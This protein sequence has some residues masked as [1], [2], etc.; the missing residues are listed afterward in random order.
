MRHLCTLCI[1][2]PHQH[3][4]H[5]LFP[6]WAKRWNPSHMGWGSGSLH[7]L[8]QI[9]G[10]ANKH[11]FYFKHQSP[12]I[13]EKG[14]GPPV[15]CAKNHSFIPFFLCYKY[16]CLHNGCVTWFSP[17]SWI[18]C[19]LSQKDTPSTDT[20][21]MGRLYSSYTLI[22]LCTVPCVYVTPLYVYGVWQPR[23]ILHRISTSL[24]W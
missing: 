14:S 12:K 5:N 22:H 18:F 23:A 3:C 19:A 21:A 2:D 4:F 11:T 7:L 24:V 13:Y 16:I 15:L 17:Q 10:L 20:K 6:R 8:L 1:H 9:I